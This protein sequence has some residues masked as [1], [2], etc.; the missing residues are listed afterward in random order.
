MSV[1]RLQYHWSAGCVPCYI[2]E[3]MFKSVLCAILYFNKT[4]VRTVGFD[5]V[6]DLYFVS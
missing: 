4:S 5:I 3:F 6:F 2:F 1:E